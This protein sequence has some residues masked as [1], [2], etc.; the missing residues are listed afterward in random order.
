M[1]DQVFG[2]IT[3]EQ[4]GADRAPLFCCGQGLE[5]QP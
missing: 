3:V 5:G 1:T 4:L 2:E